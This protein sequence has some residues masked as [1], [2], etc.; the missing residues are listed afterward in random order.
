MTLAFNVAYSP[1]Q[2]IRACSNN[3]RMHDAISASLQRSDVIVALRAHLD[4]I[5]IFKYVALHQLANSLREAGGTIMCL[6][7]QQCWQ[8]LDSTGCLVGQIHGHIS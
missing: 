5:I 3:I 2:S 8:C 6:L 7:M 4:A 1:E